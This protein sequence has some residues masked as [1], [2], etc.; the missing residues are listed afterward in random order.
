[1]F[2]VSLTSRLASWGN[3]V[4]RVPAPRTDRVSFVKVAGDEA[5]DPRVLVT[6]QEPDADA[7]ERHEEH[8]D[9][10]HAARGHRR[11]GDDGVGADRGADVIDVLDSH[12][13]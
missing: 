2:G 13:G 1:M 3:S 6:G 9:D 4:L 7:A 12:I 10:H 5:G 11:R 8:H